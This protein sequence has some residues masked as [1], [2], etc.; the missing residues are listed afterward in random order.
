[1]LEEAVECETQFAEDMLGGG[2]A[3]LSL[4]RHARSTSSTAPTSAWRTLGHAASAT[5]RRTRSRFMDLQ[6]VQELTNFFERR[7]SAYQVGVQGE[8]AF[9]ARVLG[10]SGD[11]HRPHL[12]ASPSEL[13]ESVPHVDQGDGSDEEARLVRAA[14]ATFSGRHM[15]CLHAHAA[16]LSIRRI[17]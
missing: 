3:G 8:V 16:G 13:A 11:S 9:D 1:M 15:P 17:Q 14:C 6:D 2:V 10:N 7:V 12:L 4:A 5:A